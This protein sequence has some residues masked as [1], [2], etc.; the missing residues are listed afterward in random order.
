[1]SIVGSLAAGAFTDYDGRGDS[2]GDKE[3]AAIDAKIIESV[4]V[5]GWIGLV[6]SVGVTAKMATTKSNRIF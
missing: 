4:G 6:F 5:V 3:S 1:M 2:G